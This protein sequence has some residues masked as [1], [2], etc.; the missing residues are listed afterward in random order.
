V[1]DGWSHE[2]LVGVLDK[3]ARRIASCRMW[4]PIQSYS[5]TVLEHQILPVKST[6]LI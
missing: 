4:L 5:F 2:L 3:D 6:W 1:L